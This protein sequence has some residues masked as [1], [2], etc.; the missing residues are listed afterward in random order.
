MPIVTASAEPLAAKTTVYTTKT[1]KTAVQR[2]ASAA[3]VS[4][5]AW[6]RRAAV[7]RLARESQ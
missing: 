5:S 4:E 3:N 7:E 6:M 1:E 2:A